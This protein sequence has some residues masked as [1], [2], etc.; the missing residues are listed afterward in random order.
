MES[1]PWKGDGYI[2][3]PQKCTKQIELTLLIKS[4]DKDQK[5]SE[6]YLRVYLGTFH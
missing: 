5:V 3:Y 6:E 1:E 2:L 4:C